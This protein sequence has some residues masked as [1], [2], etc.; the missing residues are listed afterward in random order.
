MA[1]LLL[2][3]L[4]LVLAAFA[5]RCI[6]QA[7]H[8][9]PEFEAG[10]KSFAGPPWSSRPR[11]TIAWGVPGFFSAST[12][13]RSIVAGLFLLAEL[14]TDHFIGCRTAIS[15]FTIICRYVAKLLPLW[16]SNA[17]RNG[18]HV[19]LAWLLL[20]LTPWSN[21]VLDVCNWSIQA[22]K[23]FRGVWEQ[24]L[25]SSS[26]SFPAFSARA[27]S[28]CNLLSVSLTIPNYVTICPGSTIPFCV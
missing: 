8:H 17:V 5:L 18:P 14:A 13:P 1:P 16:C 19:S 22:C 15:N 26:F 27:I 9:S 23:G 10:P 7:L 12:C 11:T 3:W 6:G 25:F 21:H 4:P 24:L 20:F 2:L 28:V